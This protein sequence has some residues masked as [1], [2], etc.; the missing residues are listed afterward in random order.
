MSSCIGPTTRHAREIETSPVHER[1]GR[2]IFPSNYSWRGGEDS[3]QFKDTS[4]VAN[5]E[6]VASE[7]LANHSAAPVRSKSGLETGNLF[8]HS[9]AR[10]T[11]SHNEKR[12]CSDSKSLSLIFRTKLFPGDEKVRAPSG[13]IQ[14][15]LSDCCASFTPAFRGKHSD[16]PFTVDF[17][18]CVS[19]DAEIGLHSN[20]M[21]FLHWRFGSHASGD[22]DEF[23]HNSFGY[24][25]A[26][27]AFGLTKQLAIS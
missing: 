6:I 14:G 12:D 7:H 9:I 19:H 22:A 3:G 1:R 20:V 13:P 2:F 16:L 15:G 26:L 10:V 24:E 4:G 5:R 8:F 21:M 23:Y 17:C 25:R 11:L 27:H 18:S